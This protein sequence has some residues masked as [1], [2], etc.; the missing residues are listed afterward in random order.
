VTTDPADIASFF[1]KAGIVVA[2]LRNLTT[3]KVV[4]KSITYVISI[5]I[6]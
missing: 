4:D 6:G 5:A 3:M 2:P 1:R